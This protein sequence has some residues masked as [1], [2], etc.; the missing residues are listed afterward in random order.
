MTYRVSLATILATDLDDLEDEYGIE[1]YDDG[2][3]WDPVDEQ[4]YS[5]V[6]AWWNATNTTHAHGGFI[7]TKSAKYSGDDDM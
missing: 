3:V 2:S 7:S 4:E 1:I 5:T 6:T